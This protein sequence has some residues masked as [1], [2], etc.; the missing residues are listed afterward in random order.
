MEDYKLAAKYS[1]MPNRLKY[2]GPEDS[3]Q[4]LHDFVVDGKNLGIVKDVLNQFHALKIYLNLISKRNDKNI[5]DREVL[6]S[7]W[8]GNKL[9][10]NIKK[11]EIKDLILNEFTKKG[12]PQSSAQQ[13]A[14]NVP[15]RALPHHSFHVFHIHSISGK[16]LATANNMDKCRISSGKVKEI[17]DGT[18]VVQYKP[19]AVD[20]KLSFGKETEKEIIYNKNFIPYLKNGDFVA[21]H[22]DFAVEKLTPEQV[23]NLEKYTKINMD[24]MNTLQA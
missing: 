18:A 4:V 20:E 14:Q 10:E 13:L 24:A 21:V 23:K 16:L 11:E 3:D 12:L 17:K 6:E 22:W 19:I 5:F 2:C 7:Y 8:I 1:F 15:E 9:I